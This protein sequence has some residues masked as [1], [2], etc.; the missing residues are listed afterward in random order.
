MIAFLLVAFSILFG[1]HALVYVSLVHFFSLTQASSKYT[2]AS[3]LAL[4]SVSFIF[5]S[6]AAHYYEN[7]VTRT[8]YF[9]S[10]FWLGLLVNLLVAFV[11]LWLVTFIGGQFG[12]SFGNAF[13]GAAFILSLIHIYNE[14][15]SSYASTSRIDIL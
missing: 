7:V 2:I 8:A 3:I 13:F 1:A 14:R 9:L 4:L 12:Y 10:G 5:A 15:N 11:I 6:I